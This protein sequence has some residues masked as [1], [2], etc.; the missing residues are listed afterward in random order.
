MP[1][2]NSNQIDELLDRIRSIETFS[3]ETRGRIVGGL[4]KDGF[5]LEELVYDDTKTSGTDGLNAMPEDGRWTPG[6][7]QNSFKNLHNKFA[8]WSDPTIDGDDVYADDYDNNIHKREISFSKS[9]LEKLGIK[10]D[11]GGSI[12][13]IN[14]YAG[15]VFADLPALADDVNWSDTDNPF[16]GLHIDDFKVQQMNLYRAGAVYDGSK[17]PTALG[18]SPRIAQAG[19][20][21]MVEQAQV[22]AAK[23]FIFD[24]YVDVIAKTHEGKSWS[25]V[26]DLLFGKEIRMIAPNNAYG[27]GAGEQFYATFNAGFLVGHGY[28][29]GFYGTSRLI[30]VF[31]KAFNNPGVSYQSPESTESAMIKY[32]N[33]HFEVTNIPF[34]AGD[35]K[36]PTFFH[37]GAVM[38][39]LDINLPAKGDADY[40][41]LRE[42]WGV[43]D[44]GGTFSLG[45][46]HKAEISKTIDF[47]T[48]V[49]ASKTADSSSGVVN[50][51]LTYKSANGKTLIISGDDNYEVSSS[52]VELQ[53]SNITIET[54][55]DPLKSVSASA[56]Q[57]LDV[58]ALNIVDQAAFLGK[59]VYRWWTESGTV[60]NVKFTNDPSVPSNQPLQLLYITSGDVL[61]NAKD[62]IN[63]GFLVS[64]AD[65]TIL[66]TLDASDFIFKTQGSSSDTFKIDAS[67]S[68]GQN[69]ITS[70]DK[71]TEV[72]FGKGKTIIED[73]SQLVGTKYVFN[74]EMAAYDSVL[75]NIDVIV[76][77]VEL[78]GTLG[79]K[80]DLS[81]FGGITKPIIEKVSFNNHSDDAGSA[82][83]DY[84]KQYSYSITISFSKT[85][86]GVT[87]N[88]KFI[89]TTESDTEIANLQTL[90][91]NSLI[92]TEEGDT[93]LINSSIALKG[94]NTAG[95]NATIG[96]EYK[97]EFTLKDHSEIVSDTKL[98]SDYIQVGTRY[99]D[100]SQ[101]TFNDAN[102]DISI[103]SSQT[104]GEY[105]IKFVLKSSVGSMLTPK[106]LDIQLKAGTEHT[107]VNPF[108][109]EHKY[110]VVSIAR[111]ALEK[112]ALDKSNISEA[113]LTL[114]NQKIVSIATANEVVYGSAN[115]TGKAF[116]NDTTSVVALE[117]KTM[118]ENSSDITWDK[119]SKN[120]IVRNAY[121]GEKI[122][123]DSTYTVFKGYI[124]GSEA[125]ANVTLD[126]KNNVFALEDNISQ[127]T[128]GGT[129]MFRNL[130]SIHGGAGNDII[131][132]SSTKYSLGNG[133]ELYGDAGNDVIWG[134]SGNDI[135]IG[136]AG[137][138]RLTGGPGND[139]FRYTLASD[140]NSTGG[141]DTI[142]HF[143]Q[144]DKIELSS[145]FIADIS[146]LKITT[147]EDGFKHLYYDA[148]GDGVINTGEFDIKISGDGFDSVGDDVVVV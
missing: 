52:D 71:T 146:K 13:S 117:V 17:G 83:K 81:E 20:A 48:V 74:D 41:E 109:F 8:I 22:L 33:G 102:F 70:D 79:D 128:L 72:D 76:N 132:L 3:G 95:L 73:K 51:D 121:T 136:G 78:G 2:Q 39:A 105:T 139:T 40:E 114:V 46:A 115:D 24:N 118:K 110:R 27:V 101:L 80:F 126:G 84:Y 130:K 122:K 116:L 147:G 16:I 11:S 103:T 140:S 98:S 4:V 63:V 85:E 119:I 55:Y 148:N 61:L 25:E 104:A 42:E 125:G 107:N 97:F 123:L 135:L 86:N 145:S 6:A 66:G 112:D 64:V 93:T 65:K 60:V 28:V 23:Q 108:E 34:N 77:H 31:I 19:L 44:T 7:W 26:E 1:I 92:Y 56:G 100:S 134:G 89:I 14:K 62:G 75:K 57:K 30:D 120:A 124:D 68:T 21:D 82:I 141:I 32:V 131:D 59:L 53:S 49:E 99:Y 47:S 142:S 35:L 36:Y 91:E 90:I 10:V 96:S 129:Q 18:G 38:S 54:V 50:Y 133:V 12:V 88:Y 111:A 45:Y 43:E 143:E 29:G 69:Y 138:D 87:K 144:G 113:D 127:N 137:A 5:P 37:Y 94:T 67:L 9:F 15:S 106:T 58:S